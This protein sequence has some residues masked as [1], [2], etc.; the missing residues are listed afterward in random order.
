M[1][2]IA[3]LLQLIWFIF[4]CWSFF[5]W[6]SDLEHLKNMLKKVNNKTKIIT[7]DIFYKV[8]NIYI[9]LI[10]LNLSNIINT[11]FS[12]FI[13]LFSIF[14]SYLSSEIFTYYLFSFEIIYILV[15]IIWYIIQLVIQF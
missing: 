13:L 10:K 11:K 15:F 12:I 2:F 14:L 6:E 4:L 8:R 9:N 5:N 1:N 7:N 3:T